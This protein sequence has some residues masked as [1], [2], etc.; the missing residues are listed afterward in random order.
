M[1]EFQFASA[2]RKPRL[3][4]N[5]LHDMDDPKNVELV[6]PRDPY[7]RCRPCHRKAGLQE[8]RVASRAYLESLA[9]PGSSRAKE[10]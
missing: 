8:A 10:D 3:C 2:R 9:A 1:G 7:T 6:R 4:R 5:G